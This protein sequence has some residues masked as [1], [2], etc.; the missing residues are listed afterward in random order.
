MVAMLVGMA[1]GLGL[2]YWDERG[3]IGHRPFEHL[4]SMKTWN[5]LGS[6]AGVMVFQSFLSSSGLLPEAGANL[7]TSGIPVA[8]VVALLPFVAGLVTGIGIGFV[9]P[10]FPLVVGLMAMEGTGLTPMAT[11]A[12]SFGFGYAGMML[13]PVHLCLVLTNDYFSAPYRSVYRQILPCIWAL[14]AASVLAFLVLGRLG[15]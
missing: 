6:L 4:R 11:L 3:R 10:A 14:L 7:V 9:G 1:A 12:L 5:I 15:L 2:I 13:S 8:S